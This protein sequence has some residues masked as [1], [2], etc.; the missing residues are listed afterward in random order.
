MFQAV[1]KMSEH[2]KV[3]AL[4]ESKRLLLEA[5]RILEGKEPSVVILDE[6]VKEQIQN[7]R[8]G[9]MRSE[10]DKEITVVRAYIEELDQRRKTFTPFE[11]DFSI[12][13]EWLISTRKALYKKHKQT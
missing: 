2:D 3:E 13:D 6:S 10:L 5:K 11:M 12:I 9:H 1:S 4:S 7:I 8:E